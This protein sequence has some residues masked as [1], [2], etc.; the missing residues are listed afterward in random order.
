MKQKFYYLT[1]LA[2]MLLGF[3]NA[4]HAQSW[5]KMMQDPHANFY[6]IRD[7]FNAWY[8]NLPPG[9]EGDDDQYMKFQRW[10]YWV[11]PRCYPSGDLSQMQLSSEQFHDIQNN[12]LASRSRTLVAS[13]WSFLGPNAVPTGGGGGAGRVN[14]V[15]FHP[16]DTATF[17]VGT[18][19]GGLWKTTNGGSSYTSLTDGLAYLGCSDLAINPSNPNVMYLATGDG[20]GHDT[21]SFGV[22]HTANAGVTWDTTGFTYTVSSGSNINRLLINP[23]NPNTLFAGTSDGVWR[24][25]NGGTTWTHVLTTAY[26]DGIKDMEFKPGDTTVLYAVGVS[27]HKSTNGGTSFSTITSGLPS[28]T[29][30]DRLAIGVTAANPAYVYVLAS[31]AST[32]AFY[33]LYRS[34]NS[35]TSFATQSTSPNLLGFNSTGSD[36]T[37]QGWYTLSIGVS[38]TSATTVFVGGVNMWKSTDGGVNWTF[39]ADWTGGSAPYVHAD[40]HDIV[41]NP[42]NSAKVYVGCDGGCFRSMNTGTNWFDFSSNLAIAQ[43]YRIGNSASSVNMI[44]SGHQDNGTNEKTGAS[45]T[46]FNYVNGGDGMECFIDRTTNTYQYSSIY[47]GNFYRSSDGGATFP[48]IGTPSSGTAPWVTSWM[49]DYSN[50]STLY[51]GYQDVWKSTN[52]GNSWSRLSTF[53]GS[54]F[55]TDVKVSAQTSRYLYAVKANGPDV[56]YKSTNSGSTWTNI[57]G[58]LPVGSATISRIEVSP[59]D[60]NIIYVCF[61]GYSSGN[62]VFRS[63]NGGSTWTNWSTGLPNIPANVLCYD[64]LA[65]KGIYVGMDAGVYYR[66]TTMSSWQPFNNNLPNVKIDDLEIYYPT[67]KLRAG[68]YGRGLW[69]SILAWDTTSAGLPPVANFSFTPASPICQGDTVRFTDLSTNVPTAWSWTFLGGTPATSSTQ[70]PVI[71][72]NTV[73]SDTVRL[74]ATNSAGSNT[75][76]Q[77][78]TVRANPLPIVTLVGTTLSTTATGTYQWYRNGVLIAGATSSSYVVTSSGNFSVVVTNA[79][80]CSRT[81]AST[82]VNIPPVANFSYLPSSVCIGD[83][84]RFTD[85]TTNSPSSWAWTFLNGTPASSAIQNPYTVFNVAGWDFVTLRAT[86][87]GGSNT[88]KIGINV[89]ANPIPMV[90]LV[91]ATLSTTDVGTYQWYFNGTLIPG[92]T[93]SS[94]TATATGNY[95][96]TVTHAGGCARSSAATHVTIAPVANYSYT[97]STVCQF[98]T[99]RF[100][101]LSANTPT[102]WA[103]TFQN[104]T[105]A[106]AAIQN[107]WSRFLTSGT[108]TVRLT[109]SNAGGSN[110][111][112]SLLTVNA[113]PAPVATLT[114]GVLST[115]A[116]G[117]YQ[118]YR[119]GV[120]LSGATSSSYTPTSPGN[121][122]VRVT[123]AAGCR[124]TSAIVVVSPVP[125]PVASYTFTPNPVCVGDTI[126]FTD[127]STNA[128][129]SWSW[130][131]GGGSPATSNLQNPKAVFPAGGTFS[132]SLTATNLGGSDI[133]SLNITSHAL[134]TPT[135]TLSGYI[136]TCTTPGAYQ[137]FRNDTLI[138][139]ATASSFTAPVSG[140]YTVKVTDAFGCKGISTPIT[141]SVQNGILDPGFPVFMRVFPVPNQGSFSLEIVTPD[142]NP[143]TIRISDVL[144][145]VVNEMTIR[146]KTQYH[147]DMNLTGIAKGIYLIEMLKDEKVQTMKKVTIY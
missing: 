18:P 134:P 104:G 72:F 33:G 96:V 102:T 129:T 143:R 73:G 32:D 109:A 111:Y 65:P 91:G 51:C 41:F 40:I 118:W 7:T 82:T 46:A 147:L 48:A 75:R 20:D 50:S 115:T 47:N 66:D 26:P 68:T 89:N 38:P 69:E 88:K 84:V 101:D 67:K 28:S 126:Q 122:T 94:Y 64:K 95:T 45:T 1:F 58:T 17:F 34:T 54:G 10:A 74:T 106:T 86:N 97:P 98:D 14:F 36:A 19:D 37:G 80:G 130:N 60:S 124:N 2:L 125:A 61:S 57:T 52:R 99:I 25:L 3:S 114:A 100:T 12:W 6:T 136:M 4:M 83:T 107:P 63:T 15:R 71:V 8:N 145:S 29:L 123:N 9:D 76:T 121:Y 70:N 16:T 119:N 27:F 144:G 141:V 62:K 85:L 21:Y 77:V 132:V 117:T 133:Y 103:W 24:S 43:I 137:W 142:P 135:V 53:S 22:L 56:V 13:N 42:S 110:A 30:V 31:D 44:I 140:D 5:V 35:G 127:A 139:G 131:F 105:P 55:I 146:D 49:Q 128:P 11:E 92:A 79:S 138:P 93:A 90:T 87:A 81:S 59:K 23:Q 120:L 78:I 113:N 108:D 112:F 116:V 39:N